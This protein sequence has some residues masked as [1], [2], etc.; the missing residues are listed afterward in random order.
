MNAHLSRIDTLA[1]EIV[2]IAVRKRNEELHLAAAANTGT[3][4]GASIP[5]VVDETDASDFEWVPTKLREFADKHAGVKDG[6]DAVEWIKTAL[7]D[8]DVA[9]AKIAVTGAGET[10]HK[11]LHDWQG[12][13]G[14][15]FNTQVINNF[16]S[17]RDAQHRFITLAKDAMKTNKE[18]YETARIAEV[19]VAEETKKALE[20]YSPNKAL[21]VDIGKGVT[22]ASGI[23]LE[24]AVAAVGTAGASAVGTIAAVAGIKGAHGAAAKGIDKIMV[25]GGNVNSI[26]KAMSSALDDISGQISEKWTELGAIVTDTYQSVRAQRQFA[27]S[28][29]PPFTK[30]G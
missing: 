21:L 7:T 30:T 19:K 26:L 27:M 29:Y 4:H 13:T 15:A 14:Y 18:M 28:N 23:A 3:A 11:K 20:K 9:A 2:T 24:I 5:K 12:E 6:G 22:I 25:D 17:V 16:P 8:M 1:K 10:I